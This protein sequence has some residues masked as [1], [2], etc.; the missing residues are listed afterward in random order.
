MLLGGGDLGDHQR[1]P[2]DRAP[3][4]DGF[5]GLFYKVAWGIIK[6]DVIDTF[7]AWRSLDGRSVHPLNDALMILLRLPMLF[8]I[9]ME[10]VNSLIREA[11]RRAALMSLPGHAIT[12]RASLYADDLVICWI[13]L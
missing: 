7:N 12:H 8:V 6:Q 5:T 13:P 3:G 4:P 1:P 9:V 10:D 11:D 2:P